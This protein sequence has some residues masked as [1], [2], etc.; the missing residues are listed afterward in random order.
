MKRTAMIAVWGLL[1]GL[2][3]LA[4]TAQVQ[5]QAQ[6][7]A[8]WNGSFYNNTTFTDPA[9]IVTGING[10]NFNWPGV[11][12]INGTPVS[13]IGEN[14][15]SARFTSVQTFVPGRYRFTVTYDDAVR[16]VI[17]GQQVLNEPAAGLRT[18]TFERDMTGTHNFQVDFIEL[19]AAA[20]LQFQWRLGAPGA[21]LGPT[22]TPGPTATP[23]PT[24]L[25]PIPP[26]AL[27]ATVI[28]AS[29]LIVREAPYIGA[30][31]VGTIRRGQT[32]A[33]V[34]RDPRAY[35]FL[36]QLSDK[37]AWAWGYYLAVNGN[38]FNAPVVN[39]FVTQ[40]DPAAAAAVTVQTQAGLRLRADATVYAEQIGRIPWG[41]ILPVIGRTGDSTWY[42]VV[43][44]DT[45]GWIAAGYTRPLR[46]D[47]ST[48]PV[49]R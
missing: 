35:W 20:V 47:V 34:G 38:E 26:G 9:V 14:N 28:R 30:P 10:L 42:Q 19:S 32:F 5:A 1:L 24:S 3:G 12:T 22:P 7:G 36:L 41:Q 27:S 29:V 8:N 17:D 40:G 25:P 18:S 44:A 48:V 49:T 45:V 4:L 11:P 23:A 21:T 6:F 43:F 2:L 13:G 16:V 39:S 37:Q 15:F 33:V 46:G 31:R